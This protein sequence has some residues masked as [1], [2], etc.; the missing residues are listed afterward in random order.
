MTLDPADSVRTSGEEFSRD[1]GKVFGR[2]AMSRHLLFRYILIF[3]SSFA[4]NR[5]VL[6]RLSSVPR[7]WVIYFTAFKGTSSSPPLRMAA[8][9]AHD[10]YPNAIFRFNRGDSSTY[11]GYRPHR[12]VSIIL[13]AFFLT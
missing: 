9:A 5:L 13:F 2:A 10:G 6:P 1:D 4:E 3:S 7:L 11:A 12:Y 8:L